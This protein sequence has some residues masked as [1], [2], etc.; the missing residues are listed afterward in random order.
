M[1]P[2]EYDEL[3]S[4]TNLDL[5]RSLQNLAGRGQEHTLPAHT[6]ELQQRAFRWTQQ[7]PLLEHAHRAFDDAQYLWARFRPD[8]GRWAE[9]V[10]SAE[11]LAA[12]LRS[13]G[14]V[15]HP[16]LCTEPSLY[17]SVCGMVREEGKPCI[18]QADHA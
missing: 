3:E 18:G 16:R 17:G 2:D 13:L 9:V 7:Y 12:Q 6:S 1:T 5:V 15:P 10:R 8:T 4:S 14:D 11:T